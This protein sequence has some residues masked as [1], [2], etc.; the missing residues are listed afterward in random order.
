MY[1]LN[2]WYYQVVWFLAWT[3]GI[4][5]VCWCLDRW[6]FTFLPINWKI[7][8][9]KIALVSTLLLY[10]LSCASNI[11]D[12]K[13]LWLK[14]SCYYL[15]HGWIEGLILISY[16]FFFVYKFLLV[17]TFKILI[18]RVLVEWKWT[19]TFKH[20]LILLYHILV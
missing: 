15:V 20:V 8:I 9:F 16:D 6:K 3:A 1:F 2:G 17:P 19:Y 14:Q 18:F 13:F 4:S 12:P 11:N 7:Y 5:E 10:E